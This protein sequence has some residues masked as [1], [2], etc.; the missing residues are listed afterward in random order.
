MA[1]WQ[2]EQVWRL[3]LLI[4]LLAGDTVRG[5]FVGWFATEVHV[6][7]GLWSGNIIIL[8]VVWWCPHSTGL[9][10]ARRLVGPQA[11]GSVCSMDS[12]PKSL[13]AC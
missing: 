4:C 3:S 1:Y 10:V 11:V 13:D 2:L 12:H 7:F 8:V 9:V 5:H 6:G